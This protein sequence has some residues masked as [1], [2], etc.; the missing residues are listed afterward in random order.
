ME[1]FVVGAALSA[2]GS[3]SAAHAQSKAAKHNAAVAERNAQLA[4]NA[5]LKENELRRKAA[6]QQGR[7]GR[8]MVHP[9]YP[10]RGHLSICLSK[11]SGS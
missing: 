6:L 2:V 5:G 10:W 1:L 3:I 11:V 7:Y 8:P 4:R 9:G